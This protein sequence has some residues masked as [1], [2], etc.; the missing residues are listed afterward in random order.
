[1]GWVIAFVLGCHSGDMFNDG[2]DVDGGR[3]GPR[4]E[5]KEKRRMNEDKTEEAL[6]GNNETT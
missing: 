3:V 2:I 1:M 5:S 6:E 4:R